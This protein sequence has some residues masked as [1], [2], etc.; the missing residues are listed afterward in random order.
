M[1]DVCG[2][3]HTK[4]SRLFL[5]YKRREWAKGCR[6]PLEKGPKTYIATDMAEFIVD[7]LVDISRT[8]LILLRVFGTE[9]GIIWTNI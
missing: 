8:V 2:K 6:D 7:L 3:Q 1:T 5:N 4:Y 9:A